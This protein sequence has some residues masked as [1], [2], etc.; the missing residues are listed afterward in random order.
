[1]MM[2]GLAGALFFLGG[3]S[4]VH[5]LELALVAAPAAAYWI[6]KTPYR[7]TRLMGYLDPWENRLTSGHQLIQSYLALGSG[8]GSGVGLGEGRQK[9]FFLPE[10]HTDFVFAV[11]GEE[12]GLL[13]T[14]LTT[15]LYAAL[16]WRGARIALSQADPFGRML[17]FGITLMITLSVLVNM[18]V[19]TGLVP[20]KGL[21]LPF[22]SYGGSSLVVNLLAA[23]MLYRLSKEPE[24]GERRGAMSGY[25]PPQRI[26]K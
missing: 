19:V 18:A 7:M 9:L 10:P 4:P 20:T 16:L 1:M 5:L 24:T 3:M 21:P 6:I 26:Y 8:G 2:L 17:A 13:G 25:P 14:L 12:L 23:G 15:A 11:V 22:M